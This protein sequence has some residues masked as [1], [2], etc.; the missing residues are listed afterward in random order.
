M[1]TNTATSPATDL[2]HAIVELIAV[3][4]GIE[5]LTTR[6]GELE[7]LIR[8]LVPAGTRQTVGD[9]T[10]TVS[11]PV[12]RLNTRALAADNPAT[13]RPELYKASLDTTAVRRFFSD[14]DLEAGGYYTTSTPTVKL[15]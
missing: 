12:R 15:S 5:Q 13:A 9:H 10:I 2:E 6:R 14:A 4:A 3:R 1:T 7:D 8:A 11:T